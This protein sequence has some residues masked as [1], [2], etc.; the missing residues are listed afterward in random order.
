M[1][2]RRAVINH[3]KKRKVKSQSK[4]A[5]FLVM[6]PS[7]HPGSLQ[8]SLASGID[9]SERHCG[10]SSPDSLGPLYCK[11]WQVSAGNLE[12]AL[13]KLTIM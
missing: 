5:Y 8:D 6:P 1:I 12:E 9:I 10:T 7:H 13:T 2:N 4:Q 3:I 11:S